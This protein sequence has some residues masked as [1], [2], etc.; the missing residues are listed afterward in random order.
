VLAGN[1]DPH[2]DYEWI[3]LDATG[4]ISTFDPSAISLDTSGFKNSLA[5]GHFSIIS[6]QNDL[7]VHFTAV[8][9]PSLGLALLGF[10]ALGWR[11]PR[12]LREKE[13]T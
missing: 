10:L 12:R 13:M 6:S 11:T 5:G 1:F 4:G 3:I 8:P 7:S 9:E 2:H